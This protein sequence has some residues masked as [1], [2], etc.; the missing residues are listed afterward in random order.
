[1]SLGNPK[2]NI[3]PDNWNDFSEQPRTCTCL[4][5]SGIRFEE[6]AD[7]L[8]SNCFLC[9]H[10]KSQLDSWYPCKESSKHPTPVRSALGGQRQ[11]DH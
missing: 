9:K 7:G 8:L 11:A 2:T 6:L 3:Y 5:T 10:E 4:V 1:M